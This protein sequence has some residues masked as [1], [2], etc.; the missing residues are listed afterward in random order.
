MTIVRFPTPEN[1]E[2]YGFLVENK[3]YFIEKILA[4]SLV[5][6]AI[7]NIWFY[8]SIFARFRAKV[9]AS[10][11]I[12]LKPLK[13]PLCFSFHISYIL[14]IVWIIGWKDYQIMSNCGVRKESRDFLLNWQPLGLQIIG[15]AWNGQDSS[16]KNTS[17]KDTSV[18]KLISLIAYLVTDHRFLIRFGLKTLA[19]N[20]LIFLLW[21]VEKRL[22]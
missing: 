9:E 5:G 21:T 2:Y 20:G 1:L 19:I 4:L 22:E 15:V 17:Y 7:M 12:L 10:N 11:S 16:N 3:S 13:C 6:L 18:V 8:G 14:L